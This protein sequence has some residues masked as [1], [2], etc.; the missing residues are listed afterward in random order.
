MH[1]KDLG[2][3]TRHPLTCGKNS[4][5]RELVTYEFGLKC[6]DCDYVQ[7]EQSTRIEQIKEAVSTIE[8]MLEFAGECG[9]KLSLFKCEVR[10]VNV[11][12]I[13][14]SNGYKFSLSVRSLN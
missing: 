2:E 10:S 6:L 1:A 12:E 11:I 3:L 14:L 5:H 9:S 13:E 4:N 8:D 7:I